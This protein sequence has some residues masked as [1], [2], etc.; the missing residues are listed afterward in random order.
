[1]TKKWQKTKIVQTA[2]NAA[3]NHWSK[4]CSINGKPSIGGKAAMGS[5][6]VPK[7]LKGEGADLLFVDILLDC[8]QGL[9]RLQLMDP[10]KDNE[11]FPEIKVE[12]M[13]SSKNGYKPI[14]EFKGYVPQ[15]NIYT[16]DIKLRIA[17]IPIEYYGCN[18]DNDILEDKIV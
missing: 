12:Q 10:K 8:D 17:R 6:T 18:I 15:F 5:Y 11:S 9:M 1:M 2:W 16:S 7:F 13:P 4:G 3:M 14:D